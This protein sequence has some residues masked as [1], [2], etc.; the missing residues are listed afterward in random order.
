[1]S[2]VGK[3]RVLVWVGGY[4]AIPKSFGTVLW[5]LRATLRAATSEDS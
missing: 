3:L 4:A 1:M 5:E 2:N